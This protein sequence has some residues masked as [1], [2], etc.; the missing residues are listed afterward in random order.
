MIQV[1]R[2]SE[3]T[4]EK[5]KRILERTRLDIE[6][7]RE[8]VQEII[9]AVQNRGD[10][11]VVE[12]TRKLD[13]VELSASEL[14]ITENEIKDAYSQIP[15]S[16]LRAMQHAARNI[17]RF[18]R[19]QL[20]GQ[21]QEIEIQPGIK[22][23]RVHRP[24]ERIGIY[25]PGGTY[26]YPST[27]L[28]TIVPARVAGVREIV[29]CSPPRE[30]GMIPPAVLVSCNLAGAT[31]IYRIGGA[32]AIAAMAYGTASLHKV[33]KIFGPGNI[34][35]TAA[36][37]LAFPD[38]DIDMPAG[39][40]EVLVLADEEAD[41]MLIAAD[42]ISQAEHGPAGSSPAVLVTSSALLADR[43]RD[44][45]CRM[46]KEAPNRDEIEASLNNCGAL[47]LADDLDDAV[48]FANEYAPEHLEI[49]LSN[50]EEILEKVVNAGTILLGDYSPVA[51]GDYATGAN[52]V[53]PTSGFAKTRGG[54]SIQ[55]FTKV[56][57]LQHLSKE[58]LEAIRE[59][60]NTL[61]NT[62][63]LHA[64]GKAIDLRFQPRNKA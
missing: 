52:H 31:E 14:R 48:A 35:I 3:L 61:A 42:M 37:I 5:R 41:P 34:Y 58:G 26:P 27:A 10:E 11:A 57:T 19:F 50:P 36:K 40:S 33:A 32:Q 12:Y 44:E 25:I 18:H 29:V 28:M 56:I 21:D 24:I 17:E 49:M 16:L 20:E 43:V 6:K 64:H 4:E 46:V 23:S 62:E 39:P 9:R 51:A 7:A 47:L 8:S 2:L 63:H 54:L 1:E 53:L 45:I 13:K 22:L 30:K 60:I 15:A 38:V 59:T 55:D